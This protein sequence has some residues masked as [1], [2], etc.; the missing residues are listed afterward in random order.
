MTVLSEWETGSGSQAIFQ[1]GR[2]VFWF[3]VNLAA[4]YVLSQSFVMWLASL[5]HNVILP[6]LRMPSEESLFAFAFDHLLLFSLLCGA[7]AGMVAARY[8]QRAAMWVWVVPTAIFIYKFATF[9]A[10]ILESHFAATFHYYFAGGFLIPE[11]HNA[12]EMFAGWNADYAW[13]MDQS[14]FAAPVYV[15]F[16]YSCA[17]WACARLGVRAPGLEVLVAARLPTDEMKIED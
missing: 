7:C 9:P 12:Q 13:G 17:V 6:S 14:Q 11:F 10:S 4:I 5:A 8:N 15:S 2:T 3:S 1:V 16:A